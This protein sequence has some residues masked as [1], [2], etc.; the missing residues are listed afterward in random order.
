MSGCAGEQRQDDRQSVED[1]LE[2]VG[3]DGEHFDS[4]PQ[5][6]NG[7][8]IR[9]SPAT[10]QRMSCQRVM[11]SSSNIASPSLGKN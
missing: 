11:F 3:E 1:E 4:P 7:F 2:D 9:T 6:K 8:R 5:R 10:A